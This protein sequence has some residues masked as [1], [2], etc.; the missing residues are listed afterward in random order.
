MTRNVNVPDTFHEH[1]QIPLGVRGIV[2]VDALE[3]ISTKTFSPITLKKGQ[4]IIIQ[5]LSNGSYYLTCY[6]DDKEAAR[7]DMPESQ[8]KVVLGEV[9]LVKEINPKIAFT[10]RE[11]FKRTQEPLFPTSHS[12]TIEEIKQFQIPDCSLLATLQAI[13]NHPQ[14]SAYIRSM[15]HDNGDGT[16]TVRFFDPKT[17][18]P[19]YYT[20]SNAVAVNRHMLQGHHTAL[21]VHILEK[22]FAARGSNH[23]GSNTIPAIA[24]VYAEGLALDFCM[25]SLTRLP[26]QTLLFDK[27]I[28]QFFPENILNEAIF[29]EFEKNKSNFDDV[30]VQENFKNFLIKH[31]E[32]LGG[33][34][35]LFSVFEGVEAER[36]KQQYIAL[37][38]TILKTDDMVLSARD[39]EKKLTNKQEIAFYKALLTYGKQKKY[40]QMAYHDDEKEVVAII[41]TALAQGSLMT[42][43]CAVEDIGIVDGHAYSVIG[44]EKTMQIIVDEQTGEKKERENLFIRLRNPWGTYGQSQ[45]ATKEGLQIGRTLSGEFLIEAKNFYRCFRKIYISGSANDAFQSAAQK[46]MLEKNIA[47]SLNEELSL[48]EYSVAT[49]LTENQKIEK[50]T[51]D[52][53]ALELLNLSILSATE[54]EGLEKALERAD[55]SE[56]E[57]A[58]RACFTESTLKYFSEDIQ[59]SSDYLYAL[60]LS[61]KTGVPTES[62]RRLSP[63][64]TYWKTL[65]DRRNIISLF[66]Y[67]EINTFSQTLMHFKSEL[68]SFLER[69]KSEVLPVDFVLSKTVAIENQW[70]FLQEA[71]LLIQKFATYVSEDYAPFFKESKTQ[72]H[73]LF[74]SVEDIKNQATDLAQDVSENISSHFL[75]LRDRVAE[76]QRAV[77]NWNEKRLLSDSAMQAIATAVTHMKPIE[78]EQALTTCSVS[79]QPTVQ[80]AKEK[81]SELQ[82][83]FQQLKLLLGSVVLTREN[84]DEVGKEHPLQTK[85]NIDALLQPLQTIKLQ[86]Q[87]IQSP[88]V[89]GLLREL[90]HLKEMLVT[91]IKKQLTSGKSYFEIQQGS[92]GRVLDNLSSAFDYETCLSLQ[93][94]AKD[95][96]KKEHVTKTITNLTG[97]LK[98]ST[99]ITGKEMVCCSFTLGYEVAKKPAKTVAQYKKTHEQLKQLK[100]KPAETVMKSEAYLL[101]RD[102]T[103]NDSEENKQRFVDFVNRPEVKKSKI[104]KTIAISM[105]TVL[106][107]VGIGA[108]LVATH[109]LALPL[110]PIIVAKGIA[111]GSLAVSA[112]GLSS[113]AYDTK[114]QSDRKNTL[115]N[116][117]ADFFKPKKV[118]KEADKEERPKKTIG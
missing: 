75:F 37:L 54:K 66:I 69:K 79:Q 2:R 7:S 51:H 23:A 16:T 14:G 87:K 86:L 81:I 90:S 20:V 42:A 95:D 53:F 94:E 77:S 15:M 60:V 1:Q 41:E 29:E 57:K 61:E 38:I 76:T 62:L 48:S 116:R 73:H 105:L 92:V 36:V 113:I 34:G 46:I 45:E 104:G 112:T 64:H 17:K 4:K 50:I 88:A 8:Q 85:K 98:R 100:T 102:C 115:K 67:Y 13:L 114:A 72:L 117:F 5:P 6:E 30:L 58:I 44:V 97:S 49:L 103:R 70:Y 27:G 47:A 78:A 26:D 101:M 52:I 83:A 93:A 91:D 80:K 111:A 118:E 107:I 55:S 28:K 39:I 106:G 22:A 32:N 24:A 96:A 89:S 12:P 68:A 31:I 11:F 10:F 109:G 40:Q 84:T 21:W 99:T 3:A 56:R 71:F 33:F 19:S 63:Y 110:I 35:P 74:E 43:S 9:Y 18:M 65:E 25:Q 82:L 59:K 108:L